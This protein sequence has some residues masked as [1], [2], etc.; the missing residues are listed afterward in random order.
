MP[1]DQLLRSL[2][3]GVEKGAYTSGPTMIMMVYVLEK[4]DHVFRL[5]DS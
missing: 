4:E 2:A 5:V 1:R 3:N